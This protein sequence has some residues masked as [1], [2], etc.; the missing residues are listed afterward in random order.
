M[1]VSESQ[2]KVRW[3]ELIHRDN[4]HRISAG[5]FV[6]IWTQLSGNNAVLYYIVYIFEMAGLTGNTK[7]IASSVQYIINVVFTL[8][9]ILFLDRMGRRPA[10]I[11]GAFFMMIWLYATAGVMAQY[12]HYVPGGFDGSSAVTW[13]MDSTNTEAKAALHLG[14]NL[15]VLS[16][17]DLSYSTA[18]KSSIHRNIG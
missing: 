5:I 2:G 10:L 1:S 8:P 18:R 16:F 14:T 12:G 7:L 13:T 11:G 6:H 15:L 4:I 3:A 17:R 9:A